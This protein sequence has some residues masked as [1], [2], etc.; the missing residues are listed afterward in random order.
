MPS[1]FVWHELLTSDRKA[2]IAF[3]TSLFGWQFIGE[4]FVVDGERV[5]GVRETSLHPHWAPFVAVKDPDHSARAAAGA[6]GRVAGQ[7]SSPSGIVLIDPHGV[8]TVVTA[9]QGKDL[10]AWHILESS[11]VHTSAAWLETIAGW[12]APPGRGLW[13]GDEQIASLAESP[14][15]RWLGLA[16]VKSH[17]E[18]RDRAV[19]LGA[20]VQ[21]PDVDASGHG[22]YDVIVDPQGAVL[23]LFQGA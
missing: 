4:S 13:R 18:A 16:L 7:P 1:P 14:R 12:S 15:D 9:H 6:G 5:A 21:Q 17:R 19:S 22:V 2:A 3:Y 11:D 8:P 23:A 20:T 10:F